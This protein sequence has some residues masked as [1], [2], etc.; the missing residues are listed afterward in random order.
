[1]NMLFSFLIANQLSNLEVN[2]L[3]YSSLSITCCLLTHVNIKCLILSPVLPRQDFVLKKSTHMIYK[4]I[5][6]V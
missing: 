6:Q 3:I 5:K 2:H 4:R 1:M